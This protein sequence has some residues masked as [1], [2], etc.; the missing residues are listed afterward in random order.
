MEN[1]QWLE[2]LHPFTALKNLYLTRGIAERDCGALQE[3]SGERATEVSPSLR[4][5]FV[6][7]SSL[8]P[9]QEAMTPFVTA[10]QLSGLPVVF[11]RWK[12]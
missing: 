1:T 8:Q 10:R 3:V 7:G 11:D 9:V 6:R 5:L 4:N 12:G 2:L